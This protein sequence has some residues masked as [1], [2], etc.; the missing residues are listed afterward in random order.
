MRYTACASLRRNP[1]NSTRCEPAAPREARSV[2]LP[3]RSARSALSMPTRSVTSSRSCQRMVVTSK[4]PRSLRLSTISRPLVAAISS[5]RCSSAN[6]RIWIAQASTVSPGINTE[7]SCARGCSSPVSSVEKASLMS[8][9]RAP[10]ASA[11]FLVD[12]LGAKVAQLRLDDALILRTHADQQLLS[13]RT[14]LEAGVGVLPED[15]RLHHRDRRWHLGRLQQVIDHLH[16]P[17]VEI[18]ARIAEILVRLL[19]QRIQSL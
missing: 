13:R 9:L 6:R 17:I 11:L 2:A 10:A 4:P 7:R 18:L 19:E 3:A 5:L 8:I 12:D 14:I 1:R 16:E 15:L